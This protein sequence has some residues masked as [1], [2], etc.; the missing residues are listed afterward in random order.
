MICDD[1]A[2]SRLPR[3]LL[4]S[5]LACVALVLAQSPA[6][7]ACT[8]QG[9][10]RTLEQQARDVDVVFR[11]T[12][13][14]QS[15]SGRQR[16]YTLEVERIYRGRVA[17]TPIQVVTP[18]QPG[19]CGLGPLRAERSYVVFADEADTRLSARRCGGT[20][21]STP[22]FLTQVEDVLGPGNTLPDPARPSSED[23][24]AVEFTRVDDGGAP[25]LTR[26]AAPGAAMVV[27]GLLGLLLFR[28]RG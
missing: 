3:L 10:S 17:S 18:R 27:V 15:V 19:E 4:A 22:A 28:R 21:R 16:V 24:P 11:G 2:V 25:D 7:A 13:L 9:D 6:S 1:V 23:R 8:C 5:V 14:D 12:L 20:D 26:L